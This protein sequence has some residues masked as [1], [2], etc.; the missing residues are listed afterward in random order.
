MRV[1]IYGIGERSILFL[2]HTRLIKDMEIISFVQ[3]VK[4]KDVLNGIKIIEVKELDPEEI[5]Y[6]V[7]SS[8]KYYEDI[9]SVL[10]QQSYYDKLKD[11]IKHI[12]EFLNFAEMDMP[13][14][15]IAVNEGLIFVAKSEDFVIPSYMQT[16]NETWSKND[17]ESFLDCV[18]RIYGDQKGKYFLD[19]GANIGTI[20]IYVRKIH[21]IPVIGF[22]PSLQNYDL[23]RVNCII[24]HTEDI[25]TENLGL[26]DKTGFLTY[27]YIP[28]N[29]GGGG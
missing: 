10:R 8:E 15:S 3:T 7:I 28:S 29:S 21:N 9:L 12:Y 19:I 13:L 1:A 26:S 16:K 14:Q 22:E 25:H 20:S 6:L 17:I 18:N 23:F 27:E 5:D 2:H 24:N 4:E 11:K